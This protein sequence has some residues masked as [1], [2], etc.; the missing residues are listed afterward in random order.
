MTER[1]NDLLLENLSKL[2]S[3]KIKPKFFSMLQGPNGDLIPEAVFDAYKFVYSIFMKH[4]EFVRKCLA[5]QD[6]IELSEVMKS[7][8]IET[9]LINLFKI[10]IFELPQMLE[11]FNIFISNEYAKFRFLIAQKFNYQH[12]DLIFEY[13]GQGI[14]FLLRKNFC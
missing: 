10:E 12:M 9:R 13:I 11:V 14:R 2:I 3:S 5:L 1:I 7:Y 4:T 8:D 6:H